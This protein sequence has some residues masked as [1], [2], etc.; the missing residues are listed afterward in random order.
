[1]SIVQISKL[2]EAEF[3]WA[4]DAKRLYIGKAAPNE[5]VEVLTS[6]SNISF[7]QIDGA[8][9]NLSMSSPNIGEVLAFDGNNW[10]NSGGN[11]G[12]LISLGN[13]S[14]LSI[15]GG[16]IGYVLE[17]DGTGNLSWTPKGT[18]T[19]FIENITKANP[20]V[21]TTVDDNF[22]V[23]GTEFTFTNVPG[24]I[25]VNG[26][27]YFAN[28]QTSNSF[29]LCSDAALTPVDTSGGGYTTFPYTSVTATT[30]GTN[31]VTVGSTTSFTSGIPIKF[32]GNIFG[33]L[34]TANTY[35]VRNVANA[36]HMTVSS[37]ADLAANFALST[38]S[39]TA[40]VY[41]T[42]G[43]A[44]SAIGSSGAAAAGGANTQIQ[45]NNA[46]IL[47]A[48]ANLTFNY[49]TSNLALTGNAA[50]TGNLSVTANSS[51]SRLIS[52]VAT[53]TT[54]LVV[55][56]TTR[57]ANLNVTYANVTDFTVVTT[58]T[59]GT[60]Y[61]TFVSG[62]STANY[63]H[64][65][66]A[67]LSFNAATG[68]LSATLLTGT[69]T[70]AAQPNITS[71]GTLTA[72][73]VNGT[74]TAVALTANTGVIT[75]NG[76]GISALNASNVSTGTLAQARLA[77]SNV[78]LGSTTLVLGTTTTTVTGM[79]S[80]TSTSFTGALANGTSN[81]DIPTI[82]GNVNI[83]SAGNANVVVVTGTGANIAG[84][85]NVSGNLAAGNVSAT[86]LT[87]TL[88]TAAQP[89]I[90]SVGTLTSLAVTGNVSANN[91][92]ATSYYIH[93][94]STGLTA[95]GTVQANALALTTEINEVST[96]ASGTGV[97]L[98]TA[99][100]GMRITII[101]NGVNLLAVYPASG[102]QIN[103]L[104]TNVGFGMN[105]TVRLDFVSTSSTQWYTLNA[106][107]A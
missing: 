84:T 25:E 98:P 104:G 10:V 2:D 54:P 68:A 94:T 21:V 81:I 66:N 65:S 80:I 79:T 18:L 106:V 13:V 83:S 44:V 71:L 23:D 101:N 64:A 96:T 86:L 5:N 75:G 12:G 74:V 33:G 16:G 36:T 32:L 72:L 40:N 47:D 105:A 48:N 70:T 52:T 88:T 42:G 53:G 103:S 8:V 1:M 3:G 29:I 67:N 61:P 9:G 46:G 99:V 27:T 82:N 69:L 91:F 85:A 87:G 31:F 89:N 11:A 58:Q 73:G 35:Y 51:A 102:A 34:D 95:T 22:F 30:T 56:S 49:V 15:T 97:A 19:A 92:V 55:T 7:S 77:N 39:G 107:Y 76:S 24:M 20:G 62:N 63:A 38:A 59:T 60:F 41:G 45:F 43:R 50:I 57:V 100:A 14:N 93:S 6:Y 28:V 26:G 17:T 37:T 78:I 90:T 4:T